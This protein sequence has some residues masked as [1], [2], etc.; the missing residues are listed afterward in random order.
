MYE[1]LN[2]SVIELHDIARL[3]EQ[4]IG[5]GQ[6]SMD[7]RNCADRLAQLIKVDAEKVK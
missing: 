1:Q 5:Q 6:L 3:V 7:L 2:Q 4:E